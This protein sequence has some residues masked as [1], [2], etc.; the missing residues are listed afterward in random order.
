M[1]IVHD[2]RSDV[3]EGDLVIL[4]AFGA[5]LEEMQRLDKVSVGVRD[6]CGCDAMSRVCHAVS[7][8]VYRVEGARE[9]LDEGCNVR[10]TLHYITSRGLDEGSVGGARRTPCVVVSCG[11][12]RDVWMYPMCHV[13]RR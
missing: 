12:M 3:S 1:A 2:V 9:R 13:R 6:V 4:P 10:R 5:K 11:V 8:V 7:C